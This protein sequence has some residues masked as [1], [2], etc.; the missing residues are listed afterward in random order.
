MQP[1][2]ETDAAA[3]VHDFPRDQGGE[4]KVEEEEEPS[5]LVSPS[6]PPPTPPAP[7]KFS[8]SSHRDTSGFSQDTSETSSTL[9]QRVTDHLLFRNK[10]QRSTHVDI[11]TGRPTTRR[12][13]VTLVQTAEQRQGCARTGPRAA[14]GGR[15]Q[16]LAEML[17]SSEHDKE[18]EEEDDEDDDDVEGGGGSA[19]TANK[20]HYR[21]ESH[22]DARKRKRRWWSL[23]LDEETANRMLPNYL[24]WTFRTS[25]WTVA[26]VIY[27]Q[28]LAIIIFFALFV[29]TVG[30]VQPQCINVAG[31][32]F[33]KAG[34]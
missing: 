10:K 9:R 28:F 30:R 25:F 7:V 11:C 33:D 2:D 15:K 3:P 18:D 29:Y 27:L 6:G 13:H 5:S 22:L 21:I 14:K 17:R 8:S 24:A 20:K 32:D 23:L 16:D 12:Q 4:T 31:A 34:E 19:T 26:I 1:I